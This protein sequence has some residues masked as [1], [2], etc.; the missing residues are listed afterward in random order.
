MNTP[1]Q[2][3]VPQFLNLRPKIVSICTVVCKEISI[4]ETF[5][6]IGL[7]HASLYEDNDAYLSIIITWS[8]TLQKP[9]LN[10]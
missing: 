2:W 8:K 6:R 5:N 9:D 4:S 10:K 7:T 1:S 3:I